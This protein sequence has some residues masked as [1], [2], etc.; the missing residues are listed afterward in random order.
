M[1]DAQW[2]RLAEILPE[3]LAL[4]PA[5]RAAFLDGA[6][7]TGGVA[8]AALRVEA[9]ALVAASEAAD[10]SGALVS[11]LA[12]MAARSNA[13]PDRIGP[14]RVTGLLGE[15]GMGVVYRAERADGLFEREVALKQIRPGL[16]HAL[17]GRLD[18]ERHVLARLEHDGIA[19]LYDGGVGADDAPYVVMELADGLPIT[20]HA[21]AAGLGVKARVGLF[22]GVCDAV[23]YAHQRLVVHRDLKPSNVFV[24]TPA[25][26][27]PPRVKLLDF[28][29]AKI[30]GDAPADTTGEA[31]TRT[32]ASMTPTY[33]APEQLRRGEITTASDVYAL[34]VMLYELVAGQRPYSLAG[35]SPAE[36]ERIVCEVEPPPPSSVAP[37]DR[38]R[39]LRGDLDTICLKA[40]AKEPERR[41]SSAEALAAD[42]R[43]HLDGVP[44]EARPA[45]VGYRTRRFVRRHRV[46]VA[47]AAVVAVALIG[48]AGV[49]LWQAR[50]ARGE[51]ATARAVSGFLVGLLN[52]PNAEVDGRDVR[53]VSLLDR[54]VTGLDSSF[55]GSAETE[56]TLRHTLGMSYRSL[57]LYDSAERQLSRALALRTRL[58]GPHH[59]ATS[60]V[61]ESLGRLYSL[62]GEYAAADS[63][64]QLALATNRRRLGPRHPRTSYVLNDLGQARYETG[65]FAGAAVAWREGLAIDEATL[66]PGHRDRLASMEN[67]ALALYDGGDTDGGLAL[68]QRQVALLRRH[69]P[70]NDLT[71]GNS[72]ANL[73]SLLASAG[74]PAEA[75]PLQRE[76]VARF[77]RLHGRRHPDVGFA[78]NNY[79]STLRAVGRLGESE[80]ALRE[81][82][83]IYRAVHGTQHPDVVFP[84]VGLGRTLHEQG[85]YDE[86]ER[87]LREGVALARTGHGADSP[88]LARALTPLGAALAAQGRAAE[89]QR[90]LR[91]AFTLQ[92]AALP[93]D[94]PDRAV[95]ASLLG[96]TLAGRGQAAEAESLLVAA[97]AVLRRELGPSDPRTSQAAQRL[98]AFQRSQR[99]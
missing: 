59:P 10:A 85:R 30:L 79:G 9:D 53:V 33:A 22:V 20:A 39:A 48:G 97:D 56:A 96:S 90:V 7:T 16:G 64:L 15:G 35:A 84:L 57:A 26:G 61:Q 13:L 82:L 18:A 47:S 71:L 34:G 44:V 55:T 94:N 58:V 62:Q 70:A 66:P 17:A 65:D 95:T 28:G 31:L 45:T 27:K 87:A 91:E 80:R 37:P 4:A 74:R 3:A 78:L 8:D 69:H 89:A 41:Y 60:E 83:S 12:G 54:A 51:A 1:T 43:R 75:V 72:L 32:Q 81:S 76:A 38:A 99:P 11:P 5:E 40:L 21:D 24:T 77:R 52:A 86:A 42:L 49:A 73:G 93:A 67:L 98:A 19:R 92:Q 29:I 25:D 14:W 46:G 23:A 50:V 2:A 68:M 63:L 36:A 88:V 6:C